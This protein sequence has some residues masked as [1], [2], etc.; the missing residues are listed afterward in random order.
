MVDWTDRAADS[1]E[2]EPAEAAFT[3]LS[4]NS[5]TSTDCRLRRASERSRRPGRIARSCRA[6]VAASR[7]LPSCGSPSPRPERCRMRGSKDGACGKYDALAGDRQR[8]AGGAQSALDDGAM[9]APSGTVDSFQAI[10]AHV[11]IDV[12][13]LHRPGPGR[14]GSFQAVRHTSSPA[15]SSRCQQPLRFECI[16]SAD[17]LS[18]CAASSS[19]PLLR[20]TRL[21]LIRLTFKSR[22]T[23][24]YDASRLFSVDSF[25]P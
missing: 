22:W 15:G 20:L 16:T 1:L 24:A 13:A 4:A 25:V 11:G 7:F 10:A 9:H 21:L 3:V 19:R 8:M 14:S 6:G 12:D 5:F 23:R 17:Q 18:F 2:P